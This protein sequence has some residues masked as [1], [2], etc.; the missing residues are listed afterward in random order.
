MINIHIK[1]IQDWE[2]IHLFFDFDHVFIVKKSIRKSLNPQWN[3]Y[4]IWLKGREA[5]RDFLHHFRKEF[6]RIERRFENT[7]FRVA[8]E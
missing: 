4:Q 3:A 2:R 7:I 8:G 6:G 5:R 1:T